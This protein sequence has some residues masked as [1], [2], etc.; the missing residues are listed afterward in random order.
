MVSIA[1][2]AIDLL[3]L[4]T[5]FSKIAMSGLWVLMYRMELFSVWLLAPALPFS[6]VGWSPGTNS[7]R[8]LLMVL[9]SRH[10]QPAVYTVTFV[11]IT[12]RV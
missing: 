7:L 11:G 9:T 3:F 5:R 8:L 12:T 4:L 2:M 6:I 1:W 10:T